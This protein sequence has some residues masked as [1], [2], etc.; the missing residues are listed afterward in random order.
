[1][2]TRGNN[3]KHTHLATLA[4]SAGRVCLALALALIITGG[5]AWA[6]P[7][8][9][10]AK[11]APSLGS[12]SS[13][14]VLSAAPKP[15]GVVTLTRSI[16]NGN[17]GSSG[18]RASVVQTGSTIM[19]R[20]IAPVSTKVLTDFNKAYA[21]LAV[22]PVPITNVLTGTLDGVTLFPGV[23]SFDAAAA[24]TGVLTLD[25]PANGIWIFKIGTSGTGALTGDSFSVVMAGGGQPCNVYWWVAEAATMTDSYFVGTILSGADITITRGT[26]TGNALAKA[27]V[28]MTDTRLLGCKGGKGR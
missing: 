24:P 16:V 1:M 26:F 10:P 3:K 22:V 19:G 25:G 27:E 13:F 5:V 12:A 7:L 23:Y 9:P 20:V 11:I 2:N 21:A 4:Y 8:P 18:P 17:V 15:D 28:T 6:K 14:A